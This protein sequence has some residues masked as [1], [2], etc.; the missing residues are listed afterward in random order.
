MKGAHKIAL[1]L[2]LVLMAAIVFAAASSSHD[3]KLSNVSKN[4]SADIVMEIADN[5][6]SRMRG[7]MFRPAVVPILFVFGSPGIFPI[8]SHLVPAEFD[9]VYVSQEGKVVEV[10][11]RIPPG[12][13]RI[14]PTKAASYLLE[15][16]PEMTDELG[17]GVGDYLEWKKR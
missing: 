7:L 17:I 1:A 5:D 6:F 15:L 9:A 12:K 4:K 8:H 2:L 3:Y 16:P 14:M 13:D 10:F 11:R